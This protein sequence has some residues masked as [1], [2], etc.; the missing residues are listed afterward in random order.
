MV[1]YPVKVFTKLTRTFGGG[2]T[3]MIGGVHPISS[4]LSVLFK[5]MISLKMSKRFDYK[6]TVPS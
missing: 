1:N 5:K 4:E 6:M 2:L 3:M